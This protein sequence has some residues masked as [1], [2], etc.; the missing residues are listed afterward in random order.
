MSWRP[1]HKIDPVYLHEQKNRVRTPDGPGKVLCREKRM[2]T[3]GGPG[4]NQY[5]VLLD[6][7]RIRHYSSNELTQ[8]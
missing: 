4:T 7:G 8:L 5:R 6:D 1:N 3:N 2:N